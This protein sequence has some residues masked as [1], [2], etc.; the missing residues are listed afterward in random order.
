MRLQTMAG[1]SLEEFPNISRD[2]RQ[3]RVQAWALDWYFTVYENFLKLK[4]VLSGA[5]SALKLCFIYKEDC[6][7]SPHQTV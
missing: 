3:A 1:P 5:W 4:I 7:S 2:G 6:C